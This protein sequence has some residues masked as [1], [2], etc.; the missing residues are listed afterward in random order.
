MT[1]L[2]NIPSELQA[3]N[4][5][6]VW[7]FVQKDPNKKP[8]KMPHYA[9]TGR[10]R[11]GTAH[12][13]REDR[14]Q[15]VSFN[16]ASEVYSKGRKYSGL[17]LAML[18]DW[19]MVAVDFDDCVDGGVVH[20]KVL[21]LVG[22]TYWEFSPSGNG[23]RAFFKGAMRDAKLI[24]K[25]AQK[26]GLPFGV[27]F[28]CTKGYVT[29]TGNLSEENE[30]IGPGIVPLTPQIREFFDKYFGQQNVIRDNSDQ[31]P[32]GM[33]DEEI[34]KMLDTWDASCDYDTWLKVGMAVHH[35]TDGAGFD[36]WHDWSARGSS[37][38]GLEECQYKWES[39][40]RSEASTVVTVRWMINERPLDFGLENV[41]NDFEP[42][43]AKTDAKGEETRP[44]PNLT[45]ITEKGEVPSTAKN[46]QA[47]VSRPD[48]LGWELRE[49]FFRQ[50]LLIQ[51]YGAEDEWREA[52]DTDYTA[53]QMRLDELH[54]K[55]PSME[56]VRNAVDYTAHINGFDSAVHWLEN[57]VP[58]WDGQERIQ[59][60]AERF[61]GATD[62]EDYIK[63]VSLYAWTAHAGRVLSPGI[64]ADMM[65][66]LVGPQKRG[67]SSN[68]AAI[69]PSPD[70][71]T[72]LSFSNDDK[73]NIEK[74]LAVLSVECPELDGLT[75]RDINS[76]KDYITR[77]VERYRFPYSRRAVN[78]PRRFLLWGTTN[79]DRFLSDPTGNRRFLPLHVVGG[80]ARF[81]EA[82]R[83]QHWAE[84]RD[85]FK[86]HGILCVDE[87]ND[88]A[89]PYRQ[90]A[91]II[92]PWQET[93]QEALVREHNAAGVVYGEAEAISGVEI[94]RDILGI[95]N[96]SMHPGH[97]RRIASV[98]K[99]LGYEQK[100]DRWGNRN[101]Q[102]ITDCNVQNSAS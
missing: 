28:F 54:F 83:L 41:G 40:G 19:G 37:Y 1:N 43:P 39:F 58:A 11:A 26:R 61:L 18:S 70:F 60:Y 15:L 3:L 100:K 21:E 51:S 90:R 31:P 5:W 30:I 87:A 69:S 8:L 79:D 22:P 68:I 92:D 35:E 17:G 33:T 84:A 74:T 95:T 86:E 91:M 102:K 34:T 4:G 82:D 55:N 96:S 85:K 6:L 81:G 12:G 2:A 44:M 57:I 80:D 27:E 76:V 62:D 42:L 14:Q 99:A 97:A 101:W 65:P 50:L 67:K 32:V 23:V 63:A 13:S 24:T 20:S 53:I 47:I 71:F 93:V 73:V 36:L 10:W 75:K 49:D 72:T 45:G 94:A 38:E 59:H 25:K 16:K 29:I 78:L 48:V 98:M 46:V 52:H 89:E 66:V 64:K 9:N 7:K 77:Q 88:L 56:K